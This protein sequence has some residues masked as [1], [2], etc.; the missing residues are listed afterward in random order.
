MTHSVNTKFLEGLA[1]ESEIGN[2]KVV[3]DA[4]PEVG[5]QDRGPSPKKV[6]LAS[7]A[8]C[9][10]IDVA[11]LL[12]KMRVTVDSFEIQIDADLTEEHPKYYGEIRMKY[13]FSGVE[14]GS[15][16]KVEKAV[17]LSKDRYCGISYMLGKSSDIKFEI[18]Y[19]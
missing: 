12:K 7:L 15:K 10:G 17:N 3:M 18:V 1:F 16:A 5:G 9:T 11:S 4:Y 19:K 14:E 6:M 2:H 13:I 8:G